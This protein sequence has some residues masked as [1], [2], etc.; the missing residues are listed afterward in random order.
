M[1]AKAARALV[2]GSR[3]IVLPNDGFWRCL[4]EFE[5]ERSGGRSGVYV[6]AKT[7]PLEDMEVMRS[8]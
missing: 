3:P 6:P 5:K 1:E 2:E 8:R 4:Q 7:K